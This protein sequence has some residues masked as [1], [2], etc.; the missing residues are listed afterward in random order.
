MTIK[1]KLSVEEANSIAIALHR[2]LVDKAD[3]NIDE[4]IAVVCEADFRH[5]HRV[6]S[7]LQE[8][9]KALGTETPA[10]VFEE[11]TGTAG[12]T[13]VIETRTRF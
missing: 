2:Y 8:I 7:T 13:V 6:F 3:Q 12:T 10:Y 9:D 5:L 4:G 11:A 1:L